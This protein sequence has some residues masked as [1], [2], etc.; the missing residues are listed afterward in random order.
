MNLVLP[1]LIAALAFVIPHNNYFP[2]QTIAEVVADSPAQQAGLQ[3]GDTITA[4]NGVTVT[5]YTQIQQAIRSSP[6]KEI[7]LNIQRTGGSQTTITLVPK[8]DSTTGYG[9]IGIRPGERVVRESLPIWTSFSKG[10]SYWWGTLVAYKDAIAQW[11]SGKSSMQVSGIVGMTEVTGQAAKQGMSTLFLWAAFISINLGI[12]NILPLPALDGG[13][14]FFV[15]L[16]MIRGGRRIS[17]R[18]EGLIHGIGFLLLIGLM[19]LL[20]FSDVTKLVTTGSVIGP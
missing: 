4:I 15:F 3:A 20:V 2:T 10:A 16:E 6:N 13:R 7:S 5:D 9:M 17:P 8:L 14:I 12:V 19:L 11:I 18:T 1:L